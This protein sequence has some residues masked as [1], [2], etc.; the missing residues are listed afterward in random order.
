[1]AERRDDRVRELLDQI[2]AR[3]R[4]AERLR[5]H[6]EHRRGTPFWPERRRSGRVPVPQQPSDEPNTNSHSA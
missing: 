4:D 3:L 1:M 6:A 5:N 2:D